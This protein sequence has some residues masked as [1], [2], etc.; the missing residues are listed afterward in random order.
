[1]IG[2]ELGKGSAHHGRTVEHRRG[3]SDLLLQLDTGGRQ[4]FSVRRDARAETTSLREGG[5]C[6]ARG[7]KRPRL[8]DA[9]QL[10]R[11]SLGP[12]ARNRR[13]IVDKDKGAII[14]WSALKHRLD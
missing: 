5:R 6:R 13:I 12:A 10:L 8:I 1:M 4:S 7:R 3:V 9:G 11:K 2:R 14:H